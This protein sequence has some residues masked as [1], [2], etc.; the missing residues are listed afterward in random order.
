LTYCKSAYGG[1]LVSGREKSRKQKGLKTRDKIRMGAK[2]RGQ[3]KGG[4]DTRKFK[5]N[6]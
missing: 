1:F 5:R 2:R 3:E 6:G 4:K